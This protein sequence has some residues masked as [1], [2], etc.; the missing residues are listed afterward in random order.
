MPPLDGAVLSLLDPAAPREDLIAVLHWLAESPALPAVRE[1][2][3]REAASPTV[4][5]QASWHR[6]AA[7]SKQR[8]PEAA[9][10]PPG[11]RP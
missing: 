4:V 8:Q 1:A 6:T 10:V 3:N 11:R 5:Q 2:A 9:A 7:R